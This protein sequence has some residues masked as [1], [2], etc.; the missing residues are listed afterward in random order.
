MS[1]R[2]L[3]FQSLDDV[4]NELRQLCG[5]YESTGKWNL[6][7]VCNHL[8]CWMR[9]P[10]DGFPRAPIVIRIMMGLM[11][12]LVG[13]RLFREILQSG[14]M[15]TGLPT[16]PETVFKSD[17]A[18]DAGA[19]NRLMETIDRFEQWQG[20]V[21]PSP[22]FGKMNRADCERLQLVHCA[23]HLAFLKPASHP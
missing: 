15:K 5:N 4:R 2:N 9:Y 6:A 14:K 7:Q 16:M 11:G 22:F 8:E 17:A 18:S 10:M 19:I 13:R 20:P 3:Q 23:H 12:K 21:H 1:Q